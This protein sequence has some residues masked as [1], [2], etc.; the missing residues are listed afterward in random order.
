MKAWAVF[1]DK[2]ELVAGAAYTK[3]N[4]AITDAECLFG[5]EWQYL[6]K[7]GYYCAVVYIVFEEKK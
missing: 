7:E 4:M 5:K 3:R 2:G 1:N 6:K